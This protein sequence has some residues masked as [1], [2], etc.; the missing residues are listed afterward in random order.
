MV[1]RL[2]SR[3]WI[4]ATLGRHTG[5]VNDRIENHDI[6]HAEKPISGRTEGVRTRGAKDDASLTV[7]GWTRAGA[8]VQFF[9]SPTSLGIHR[10]DH[11]FA[12]RFDLGFVGS[13]RR[14]RQTVRPLAETSGMRCD[15]RFGEGQED[16]LARAV[17][18]LQGTVLIAWSHGHI[19]IIAGALCP[20]VPIPEEWPEDRFDL[21]WVIDRSGKRQ[22][23]R[24]VAQ[25]LL[26]G[27]EADVAPAHEPG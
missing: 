3:D 1:D 27:D 8:L 20:G 19:P 12:V 5:A 11:L 18:R 9:L 4:D 24:Q 10:P 15:D 16:L 26:A 22:T 13:S 7:R 2:Q 17:Q 21:V 6:R 23:F 25:R 14:S